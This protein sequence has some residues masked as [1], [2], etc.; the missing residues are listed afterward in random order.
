MRGRKSWG[1]TSVYKGAGEV[2]SPPE[3]EKSKKEKKTSIEEINQ[4]NPWIPFPV[5]LDD[6]PR[7]Q[8]KKKQKEGNVWKSVGVQS[9]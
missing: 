3:E 6:E 9:C 1:Q 5:S 2:P 4:T 8:N 7:G